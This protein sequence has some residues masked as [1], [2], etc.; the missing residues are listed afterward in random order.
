MI[1]TPSLVHGYPDRQFVTGDVRGTVRFLPEDV[2]AAAL[3]AL[4]IV[5]V[6]C[7]PL[8]EGK[9]LLSR[10]TR[11]PHASW[12]VNG[13]RMRKGELYGEA[14]SRIMHAELGLRLEPDHFILL[15]YYNLL[16][17]SRAQ[18]PQG[19]GCH[20]L[21]VAHTA[22]LTAAQVAA[23]SPNEEYDA[24]RWI[25][26]HAILGASEGAYHPALAAMVR[27][28]LAQSNHHARTS[29][30]GDEHAAAVTTVSALRPG[31]HMAGAQARA[32]PVCAS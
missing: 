11:L 21:S 2:Y 23:I 32:R 28:L 6:D 10:R 29:N 13:G 3:D 7:I 1:D 16:W 20:T 15:G 19:N 4:V 5:C 24:T 8:Y 31:T 12:W 9:M 18:V 26:P 30:D 27:D 17:D 25:S 14:A 22:Q